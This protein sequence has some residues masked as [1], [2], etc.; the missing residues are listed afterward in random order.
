MGVITP[1]VS[2]FKRCL[3]D[4]SEVLVI[5]SRLRPLYL[6]LGFSS[7]HDYDIITRACNL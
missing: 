7:V 1:I 6:V 3:L 4:H 2:L 5:F